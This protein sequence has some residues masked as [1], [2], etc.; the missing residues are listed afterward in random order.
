MTTIGIIGGTGKLGKWFKQFFEQNGCSVLI[1]GR[2]T[3]LTPEECASQA[4]ITII[5]VPISAT[6]DTIKKVG[7]Y[8]RKGSLL[9]DLTSIKEDPVKAM[10]KYSKSEVLGS[11]PIFGPNISSIKDQTVVLCPAR[12][13]KWFKWV[14]NLLGE[15]GAK[16]KITKPK[17]HDKMMAVI[18]GVIHFSSITISHTLK[19]LGISVQ[20]SLDF[21]S[22][23]YKLRLDMVGRILNQD[24]KLYADIEIL[25]KNAKKAIQAYMRSQKRLLKTIQDK[26]TGAFVKYFNEAAD[27]LGSFR[28]EAEEYSDYVIE[29]VIERGKK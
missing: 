3:R 15:N 2:T 16:I 11:H 5:C 23:I 6:L 20:E 17:H 29:K 18:Q 1:A 22:P 10:K 12:G 4:D 25:N 27:Y 13:K 14:K 19:E 8:V 24:P 9:M 7:P 26:D 21:S 28:K